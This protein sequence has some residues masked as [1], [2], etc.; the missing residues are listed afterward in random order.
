M[1]ALEPYVRPVLMVFSTCFWL[2]EAL[3]I[4]VVEARPLLGVM[5]VLLAVGFFQT[6]GCELFLPMRD[7]SCRVI[8]CSC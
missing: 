4:G 8:V 2:F 5:M 1:R 6:M 3:V 7:D